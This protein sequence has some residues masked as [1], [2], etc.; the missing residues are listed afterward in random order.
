M[1]VGTRRRHPADTA[2]AALRAIANSFLTGT[3]LHVDGGGRLA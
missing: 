1:G 2:S 3:T